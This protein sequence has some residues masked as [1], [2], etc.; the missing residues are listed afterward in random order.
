M[1]E[2]QRKALK[3]IGGPLL[4]EAVEEVAEGQTKVWHPIR[5]I[6]PRLKQIVCRYCG[7]CT[8]SDSERCVGCGAIRDDL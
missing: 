3:I 5:P 1:N 4:V 6:A 8:Y 2:R 7:G